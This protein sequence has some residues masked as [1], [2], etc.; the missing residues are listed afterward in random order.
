MHQPHLTL[1]SC[2][3]LPYG[4][5]SSPPLPIQSSIPIPVLSQPSVI[6]LYTNSTALYSRRQ[7]ARQFLYGED[8]HG[9]RFP[10]CNDVSSV[11]SPSTPT[12]FT[13]FGFIF[14][15]VGLVKCTNKQKWWGRRLDSGASHPRPVATKSLSPLPP[16]LPRLYPPHKPDIYRPK[17]TKSPQSL[18]KPDTLLP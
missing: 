4:T 3:I 16:S 1:L 7:L 13:L 2:P 8:E 10:L 14:R 15:V 18:V 6:T 9:R 12:W 17:S 5:S 11:G